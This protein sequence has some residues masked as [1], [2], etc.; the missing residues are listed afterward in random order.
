MKQKNDLNDYEKD[1]VIFQYIQVKFYTVGST[2]H[3]ACCSHN[4]P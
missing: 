3:N 2:S 4:L 1:F